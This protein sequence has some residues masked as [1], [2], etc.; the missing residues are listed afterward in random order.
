VFRWPQF[1][2][3][4]C[5]ER[6][7]LSDKLLVVALVVSGY[8]VFVDLVEESEKKEKDHKLAI[9]EFESR[10]DELE[11]RQP[12]IAVGF[13]DQQGHLTKSLQVQLHSLPPEPSYDALIQEKRSELLDKQRGSRSQ[14]L[15]DSVAAL[16]SA[17]LSRPNPQYQEEVEE[18]LVEYRAYLIRR[19]ERKI[20]A[21]RAHSLFPIVENQGHCPA[22]S[23]IIELAMPEAYTTPEEHQRPDSTLSEENYK[24]LG[25]SIPFEE[26]QEMEDAR[27][28]GLPK[29]PR[30]TIDNWELLASGVLDDRSHYPPP[31]EEPSNTDGPLHEV[32]DGVHYISYTVKS[33]IQH[34]PERDFEPFRLWL[35]SIDHSTVW[36]ISVEVFC[37]EL[38]TPLENTLFLEIVMG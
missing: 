24:K 36:E 35:A 5:S 17:A 38:H 8:F 7:P 14:S 32:R 11:S 31:V 15:Q 27:I 30:P 12:R 13:R 29:E 34:R 33:L 4:L 3:K 9:A 21:D 22:N 16:A 2:R 25:S 18:Y 37:A 28:C 20:A 23:V 1:Y 6:S 10:L 26:M 19:Y